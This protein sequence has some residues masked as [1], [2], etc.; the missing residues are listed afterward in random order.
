MFM[1]SL[2]GC[3]QI[4]GVEINEKTYDILLH[5]I[6]EW[7]R[8]CSCL[9]QSNISAILGNISS[10][11]ISPSRN[12]F[13]IFTPFAIELFKLF[14]EKLKESLLQHHRTVYV[15][16][17]H[18]KNEIMNWIASNTMWYVVEKDIQIVEYQNEKK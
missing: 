14:I 10:I 8:N 2:F 5:N 18:P 6:S 15:F 12:K 9:H 17:F 11:D 3:S 16:L 1:A 7:K 13:F 4:T